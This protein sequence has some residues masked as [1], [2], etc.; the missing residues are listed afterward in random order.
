MEI[1]M[2]TAYIYETEK[3]KI[4]IC[5][6]FQKNALKITRTANLKIVDFLNVTFDLTF[7]I[8]KPY[9]KPLLC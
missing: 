1:D 9:S 5:T 3:I 4:E 2:N 6:I 8:F 7:E